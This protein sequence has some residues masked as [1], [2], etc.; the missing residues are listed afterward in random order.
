M[1]VLQFYSV[2]Y[3]LTGW[4]PQL[5]LK[6][7]SPAGNSDLTKHKL[8]RHSEWRSKQPGNA[9]NVTGQILINVEV[10]CYSKISGSTT[11]QMRL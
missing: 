10:S 8:I 7:K 6:T 11:E 2:R 1:F 5:L 3:Q 4:V 9:V